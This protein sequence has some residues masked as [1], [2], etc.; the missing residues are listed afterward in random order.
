MVDDGAA[1]DE[2]RW[3]V[4]T[5]KMTNLLLNDRLP[6]YTLQGTRLDLC[7]ETTY[8]YYHRRQ[9]GCMSKKPCIVLSRINLGDSIR[10]H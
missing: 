4:L 3:R 2:A 9:R 1:A 8:I 10:M 5:E 7:R 6:R